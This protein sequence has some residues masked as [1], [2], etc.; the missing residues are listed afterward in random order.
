MASSSSTTLP[1][2]ASPFSV[3]SLSHL[4]LSLSVK[5]N[6]SNYPVWKAQALP[7]FRGQGVFGYLDGTILMPPKELDAPHPTTGDITRIPNPAYEHWLRQD[8]LILAIINTSLTEDLATARKGAMNA[9]DYFLSINQ[10]SDELALAGQP[11]NSDEILTYILAGLG[12]EYDSL[13]ST[14]TSRSDV[15]T[16]EELYSLLLITESRINQHHDTI[17]VT[18]SVNMATRHPPSFQSC[19]GN[20]YPSSNRGRTSSYRG[21]SC[22][23]RSTTRDQG[24]F[25]SLICQVCVKPGHHALKCYHRFDLSY[26]D[27]STQRPP[28]AFLAARHQHAAHEWHP[29]TGATHH[30]TMI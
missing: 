23:G 5:L 30:L 3:P 9:K 29:D 4:S 20:I 26:Q 13:V 16:L 7:Y 1:H 24:A 6:H 12:Q 22:G 17:Q 27:Q 18:A 11:L 25:S 2:I 19:P 28:Y 8:S 21:R 15:V 10:M 14:I